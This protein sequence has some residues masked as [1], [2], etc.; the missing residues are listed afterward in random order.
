MAGMA[1][2]H[3]FRVKPAFIRFD[4]LAHGFFDEIS[5]ATPGLADTGWTAASS[6]STTNIIIAT[7]EKSTIPPPIVSDL[8]HFRPASYDEAKRAVSKSPLIGGTL[9]GLGAQQAWKS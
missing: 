5:E 3:I 7:D 6:W 8:D 9:G 2:Q 4:S 1:T